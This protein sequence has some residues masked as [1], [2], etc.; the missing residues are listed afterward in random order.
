G[1]DGKGEGI[2]ADFSREA[3]EVFTTIIDASLEISR[4]Q[5]ILNPSVIVRTPNGQTETTDELLDLAFE[6]SAKYSVPNFLI[7]PSEQ[8]FSISSEGPIFLQDRDSAKGA[9]A[10]IGT[11]QLNVPRAAYEASGKDERF[12]Q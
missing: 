5:L 9:G 10:V 12:L 1:L 11:V 6:S 4:Q 2:F 3:E 7:H 8:T